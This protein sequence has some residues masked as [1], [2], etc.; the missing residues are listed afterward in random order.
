MFLIGAYF[1]LDTPSPRKKIVR[2]AA[3]P[4]CSIQEKDDPTALWIGAMMPVVEA[5]LIV[6]L[7]SQSECDFELG[8]S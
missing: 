2:K 1:A 4:R 3:P 6:V 8:F 5:R 7:R